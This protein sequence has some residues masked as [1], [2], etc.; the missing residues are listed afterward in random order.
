LKHVWDGRIA[1]NVSLL[2]TCVDDPEIEEIRERGNLF[3]DAAMQIY[4]GVRIAPVGPNGM[5]KSTFFPSF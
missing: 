1:K 5:G 3:E 2:A 4:S